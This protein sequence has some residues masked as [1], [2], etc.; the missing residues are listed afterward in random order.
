MLMFLSLTVSA[1]EEQRQCRMKRDYWLYTPDNLDKDKTYWLVV[2]VH[3][4][5]GNGKGA[6]G[7]AGWVTQ[8]DNVIAVGP[9]F[10]IGGPYYQVLEGNSDKQLL[11][12]FKALKKEFKLHDKLFIHGFSGGS[13]YAHRFA[14]KNSKDVIGVSSHSGGTWDPAPKSSSS[15][16]VW[17]I[18]CGLNDKSVSAGAQAPRIDEFRKFCGS[19]LKKSFTVK[20]F[21]TNAGHSPTGEVR[22][23]CEECFRV[24]TSGMFDFQREATKDMS[25]AEREQ[26]LKKS[27]TELNEIEFDDGEKKHKIMVNKDGWMVSPKTLKIMEAT[28]KENDKLKK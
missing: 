28:R 6:G 1:K 7:L 5:K 26:Y 13:Q 12:I 3:G 9:S 15:S 14:A 10:P 8:F 24:A 25:F 19:M 22:K 27:N 18:S 17:T 21:V 16:C 20:P 2:G 4:A 11:D 23:N